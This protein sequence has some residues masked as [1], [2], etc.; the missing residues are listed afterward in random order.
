MW[1]RRLTAKD[2]TVGRVVDL[3]NVHGT[4]RGGKRHAKPEEESAAH[5]LARRVGC[6]LD[7]SA[8]N[9]DE[10][11]TA[12]ANASAEAIKHGANKGECDNAT[13]LVH[14]GD[15]TSPDTI[16]LDVVL[17]LEPGVLQQ[18][19]DERAV[20]AVHGGAEEADDGEDVDQDLAAGPS[21][22]RL[23]KHRLVECFIALDN[24]GLDLLL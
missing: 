17:F 24:F 9:N 16:R 2:T 5:K 22:G 3:N 11:T 14:G 23:L 10:G 6:A 19:V 8:H 13:D 1:N 21:L 15:N 20:V 18:V 7:D 4:S 12:H